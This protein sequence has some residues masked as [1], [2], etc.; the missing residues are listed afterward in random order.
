VFVNRRG[1]TVEAPNRKLACATVTRSG[2]PRLDATPQPV[3]AMR[4]RGNR[5]TTM[6]SGA[7]SAA[8][9]RPIAA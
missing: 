1:D 4:G 5:A 7:E 6:R 8:P 2:T 3:G 9:M